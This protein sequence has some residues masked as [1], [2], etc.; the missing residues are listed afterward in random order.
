MR[1]IHDEDMW[2]VGDQRGGVSLLDQNTAAVRSRVSLLPLAEAPPAD[3]D[4]GENTIKYSSDPDAD[5]VSFIHVCPVGP[6]GGS[7]R[8]VV[9]NRALVSVPWAELER[10]PTN[11]QPTDLLKCA[12]VVALR[13]ADSQD[14]SADIVRCCGRIGSEQDT[15]SAT[16]I[17]WQSGKVERISFC[18]GK[19]ERETRAH[20]PL[21]TFSTKS[22]GIRTAA[23][24]RSRILVGADREAMLVYDINTSSVVF[25]TKASPEQLP[26]LKFDV[27][28]VAF[29]LGSDGNV[30]GAGSRNG[31]VLVYD[32][33]T[34]GQP[35]SPVLK[36]R[37]PSE[38]S[39]SALLLVDQYGLASDIVG[40]VMRFDMRKPRFTGSLKGARGAV[41][42]LHLAHQSQQGDDDLDAGSHDGVPLFV[43]AG[44]DGF[45]RFYEAGEKIEMISRIY[46]ERSVSSLCS[47]KL[48]VQRA[49][50]QRHKRSRKSKPH[51][52]AQADD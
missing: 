16:T 40:N 30:F 6:A 11:E 24:D 51:P 13:D 9:G 37:L 43:T 47:A 49:E 39:V 21:E 2:L 10:E 52:Q 32:I 26:R 1:P 14:V 8:A 31:Q 23:W 36:L 5:R 44:Q 27:A 7:V 45:V 42:Q 22:G 38:R 28:T 35:R 33:R 19:A 34:G 41:N 25:E 29:A 12:Q 20:V 3:G 48:L 46:T 18:A 50:A 15:A 17:L 4:Q